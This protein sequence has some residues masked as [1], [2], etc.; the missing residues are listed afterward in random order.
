MDNDDLQ[1]EDARLRDGVAVGV[2]GKRQ[3]RRL[4]GRRCDCAKENPSL[5]TGVVSRLGVGC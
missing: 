4:C 5:L 1:K 3:E 2:V